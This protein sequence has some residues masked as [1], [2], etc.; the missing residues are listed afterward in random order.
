MEISLA[1][2][3]DWTFPRGIVVQADRLTASAGAGGAA[4]GA[5]VPIGG[6]EPEN[7]G[8]V[9]PVGGAPVAGA[10]KGG[11]VPLKGGLEPAASALGSGV[12]WVGST[13]LYPVESIRRSMCSATP[14]SVV[15]NQRSGQL[16]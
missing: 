5:V 16:Y 1:T 10:P 9:E 12:R 13:A 14:S 3:R 2:I 8:F 15:P 6:L 11:F 7:G 4:A